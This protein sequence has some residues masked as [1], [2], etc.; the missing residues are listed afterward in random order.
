MHFVNVYGPERMSFGGKFDGGLGSYCTIEP[1]S[2]VSLDFV[3]SSSYCSLFWFTEVSKGLVTLVTGC[4]FMTGNAKSRCQGLWVPNIWYQV[5]M[6]RRN[7]MG[8][9]LLLGCLSI[10]QLLICVPSFVG[11]LTEHFSRFRQGGTLRLHWH[12]SCGSG[13]QYMAHLSNWWEKWFSIVHMLVGLFCSMWKLQEQCWCYICRMLI[14][15]STVNQLQYLAVLLKC[16]VTVW[17]EKIIMYF[18]P[19]LNHFGGQAILIGHLIKNLLMFYRDIVFF[20]FFFCVCCTLLPRLPP[21][22]SRY[23]EWLCS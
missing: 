10:C 4:L 23:I 16:C 8:C 12:L 19:Y 20:F 22:L 9:R 11:L 18:R 3:Y 5:Y 21:H 13:T 1:E 14:C 6:I 7:L 2:K 17:S 15:V